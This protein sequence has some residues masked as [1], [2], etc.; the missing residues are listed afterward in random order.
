MESII[1]NQ[2]NITQIQHKGFLFF[3]LLKIS[4]V[5]IT[6]ELLKLK[7]FS[8]LFFSNYNSDLLGEIFLCGNRNLYLNSLTTMGDHLQKIKNKNHSPLFYLN[9]QS[10]VIPTAEN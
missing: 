8:L 4:S 2:R 1:F 7:E 9:T 6:N 10:N 5:P 3:L